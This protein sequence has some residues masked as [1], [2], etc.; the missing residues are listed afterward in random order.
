MLN[1]I[2]G[3]KTVWSINSVSTKCV[4]KSYI[5]FIGKKTIWC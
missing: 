2:V 5:W 1:W 4:N 3:N